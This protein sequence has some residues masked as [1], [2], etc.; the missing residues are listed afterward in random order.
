MRKDL[1]QKDYFEPDL[2]P[3]SDFYLTRR[4]YATTKYAKFTFMQL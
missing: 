2:G 4:R 1:P 3:E